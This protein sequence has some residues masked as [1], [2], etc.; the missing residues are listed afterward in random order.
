MSIDFDEKVRLFK[1]FQNKWNLERLK[2]M[3]L[4]EYT[5]TMLYSN[6]KRDDFAYWVEILLRNIGNIRGHNGGIGNLK[7]GICVCSNR[8]M[9]IKFK[10]YYSN[11]QKY[12]WLEKYGADK[13]EQE[14][15]K[16]IKEKIISIAEASLAN[17]LEKIEEIDFDHLVKW[18][19]AFHY[20]NI[21]DIK[22]INIFNKRW[23]EKIVKEEFGETD[24][25]T[26]QMYQRILWDK[27]YSL[28]D[29][30]QKAKDC[31]KKY[32]F[33]DKKK[34]IAKGEDEK[35]QQDKNN[36]P[37]NQVNQ[38][39]YGPPATGK[40]YNIIDRALEILASYDEGLK[41]PSQEDR[42]ARKELF[43]EYRQKGQIEFVTFHQ[44]YGYEEFVEG[45]KPKTDDNGNV[46]YEVEKGIFK[47]LCET[48]GKNLA[49]SQKP[50]EILQK[51]AEV[52]NAILDFFDKHIVEETFFKKAKKVGLA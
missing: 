45:I 32:D 9:N 29:I 15:F 31:L 18:K 10:H 17:D 30:L 37:L 23:L 16:V 39:L 19:I 27:K 5:S 20:Q 36:T 7:F 52:N 40:T 38:I 43:D 35:M 33:K 51:E 11:N 1:E 28:V 48:A 8:K 46:V 41:L 49:D 21:S 6:G 2:S 34:K 42:K 24:L 44:S 4:E 22:I 50:Q 12:A 13:N 14:V 47:K 3:T 25:K 26:Y